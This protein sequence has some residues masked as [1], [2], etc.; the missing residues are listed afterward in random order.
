MIGTILDELNM[1]V[2]RERRKNGTRGGCLGTWWRWLECEDKFFSNDLE[3]SK[4]AVVEV[5][6][7]EKILGLVVRKGKKVSVGHIRIDE[8]R[9]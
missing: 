8:S 5:G 7:T 4:D 1:G 6:I 2:V 3:F 9:V